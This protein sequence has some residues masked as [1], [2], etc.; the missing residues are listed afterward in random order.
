MVTDKG[1]G[2]QDEGDEVKQIISSWKQT[3]QEIDRIMESRKLESKNRIQELRMYK[4]RIL[5][6]L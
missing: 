4:R 6:E 5:K 3:K 2:K 1:F